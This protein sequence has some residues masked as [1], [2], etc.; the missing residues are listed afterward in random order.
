MGDLT[1][2]IFASDK[3]KQLLLFLQD[4]PKTWDEIKTNL[5]V[6]ASGMLPQIHILENE[7]LVIRSGKEFHLSDLGML[8]V[9]FM[10]PLVSTL[11]VLESNKRFWKEH[12]IGALP[13]EM[14]LRLSELKGIEVIECSMED[15]F[16]PHAQFLNKIRES[17]SVKGISPIV[18]PRYPQF[19]LEGA[20]HGK[21]ISLILTNNAFNK[22][23]K[24][25][26]PYLEEGLQYQNAALYVYHGDIHFAFI[27]TEHYFSLSLFFQ[28]DVFDSKRDLVSTDPFALAWGNDLFTYY[29]ALSERIISLE[30]SE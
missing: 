9:H 29:R 24:E 16:E 15:C 6:T 7:G 25:Y 18:H 4:G 28:N 8:V 19:F 12:N 11:D 20:K 13:I 10:E 1:G 5:K 3:R 30:V 26:S 22:I 23:K 2:I 14:L 17:S 27:V 21:D